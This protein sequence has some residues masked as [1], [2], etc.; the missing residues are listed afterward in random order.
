MDFIVVRHRPSQ[1]G[2]TN[3]W[4]FVDATLVI[5]ADSDAAALAQVRDEM[6]NDL[7][8]SWDVV[9]CRK[10]DAAGLR[11]AWCTKPMKDGPQAYGPNDKIMHPHCAE[12]AYK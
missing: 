6:P 5:N 2:A 12:E 7:V 10:L 9:P 11:C 8:K 1:Q 3:A 4:V